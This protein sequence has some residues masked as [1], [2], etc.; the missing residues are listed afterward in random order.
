M[1]DLSTKDTRR[2][3]DEIVG[4]LAAE[5]PSLA[6]P[7]RMIPRH[8]VLMVLATA[9][10]L[11]WAGLSVLMVVWGAPGVLLAAVTVAV[12]AGLAIHRGRRQESA[13][14]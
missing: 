2:E 8:V 1:K 9:G 6:R 10:A 12:V 5:E 7:V 4:R 3:F 11:V 14:R 13:E